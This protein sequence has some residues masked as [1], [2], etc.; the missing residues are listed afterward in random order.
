[1]EVSV[2]GRHTT[3]SEKLRAQAE[4]KIGRLDR[5]LGGM[6]RAEVHFWEEKNASVDSREY[7][8][9]TLEGHG[10][11]VR[12]KVHA[13][14]GFT[15]IDLAVDKLERQ[16]RK[17]KT[18]ME[19]RRHSRERPAIDTEL[20]PENL[21]DGGQAEGE[22][23]Y[24]IVKSKRFELTSMGPQEAALQMDLLNH[25]FYVFTNAETEKSAVVYRRDDG[26]IGLIDVG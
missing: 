26:D 11:H 1:M 4:E 9:V 23:L 6:D 14:D 20:V 12:C 3:I 13:P 8:E 2:S 22:P 16:L 10:H 17:L 19:R 21:L 5:Y 18:K 15:A 7:C 25:D 24:R